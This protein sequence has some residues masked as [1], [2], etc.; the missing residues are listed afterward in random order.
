MKFLAQGNNSYFGYKS[1]MLT[2]AVTPPLVSYDIYMKIIMEK[3][4]KTALE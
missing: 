2:I 1:D 4:L 3:R